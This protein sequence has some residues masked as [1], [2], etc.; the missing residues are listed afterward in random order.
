MQCTKG[1]EVSGPYHPAAGPCF[2]PT[3]TC[4]CSHG[5]SRSI[6]D[7]WQLVM[8]GWHSSLTAYQR[9]PTGPQPC[10]HR[11]KPLTASATLHK[12]TL[13]LTKPRLGQQQSTLICPDKNPHARCSSFQ[14]TYTCLSTQCFSQT[15]NPPHWEQI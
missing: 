3:Q 6:G 10:M 2:C 1:Q 7:V 14:N 13:A 5:Y 9:D 8:Q 4:L 11:S 15:P 12:S